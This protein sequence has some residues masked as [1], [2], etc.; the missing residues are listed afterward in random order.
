[1]HAGYLFRGSFYD[2]STTVKG[3]PFAAFTT[4]TWYAF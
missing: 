2:G 3:N 4:F 1:V